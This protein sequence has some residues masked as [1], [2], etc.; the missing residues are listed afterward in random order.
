MAGPAD[1]PFRVSLAERVRFARRIAGMSQRDMAAAIG[2]TIAQARR[3]ETGEAAISAAMLLRIAVA[4]D[5]PPGW[6]YGIDDTDH[7]P[8]TE[9]AMLLHDPEMPA[10]VS[11]FARIADGHARRLVIAM[12][13][14]L[15]SLSRPAP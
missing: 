5:V 6:L 9:L 2:T 7:W 11:A 14:E 1:G 15:A 4:L 8:N 12:A 10:L 3:Y 13:D